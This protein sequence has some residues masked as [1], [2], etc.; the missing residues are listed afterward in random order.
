MIVTHSN[1]PS[2]RDLIQW[3]FKSPW[4]CIYLKTLWNIGTV[5]HWDFFFKRRIYSVRNKE[6]KLY[7]YIY[8]C[9]LYIQMYRDAYGLSLYYMAYYLL[10]IFSYVW[11]PTSEAAKKHRTFLDFESNQI[12]KAVFV[13]VRVFLCGSRIWM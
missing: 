9:I 11:N 6:N 13:F 2:V 3:D 10:Y 1:F 8:T 4:I 12:F 7:L 5:C